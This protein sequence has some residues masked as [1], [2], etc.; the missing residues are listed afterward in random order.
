MTPNGVGNVFHQTWVAAERDDN[1]FKPLFLSWRV[2]PE[3]DDVWHTAQARSMETW[4]LAQEHPTSAIEAFVQSG[5]PVFDA[6]YLKRHE[7]RIHDIAPSDLSNSMVDGLTIWQAPLAGHRYL[8]SADVAEGLAG[9]DFDAAVVIDATATPGDSMSALAGNVVLCQVA[10]LR[11]KWAP[12]IFA[13]KLADLGQR[14]GWPLLAVERNNHGHACLLQ[15]RE[16]RY[17]RLYHAADALRDGANEEPRPGWLTTR[18]TKPLIIDT[19]A[20][21]LRED[22]YTPLDPIFLAEALVYGYRANGAMGA[23]SGFHDDVVMAHAIAV[24]IAGLPDA[25]HNAL[26]FFADLERLQE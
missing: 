13:R 20:A 10:A 22:T 12:D 4:Q 14:Y 3:R 15:L 11:G 1:G 25:A 6:L 8:I 24:Y 16:L 9:G 5:R 18:V 26:N 19:L 17:P 23:P 7:A 2:H 21:A